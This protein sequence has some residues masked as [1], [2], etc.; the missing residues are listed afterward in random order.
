[1]QLQT[2]LSSLPLK[3]S[4]KS[5]WQALK[6]LSCS[7][8]FHLYCVLTVLFVESLCTVAF[9]TPDPVLALSAF[10]LE[11]QAAIRIKNN[12]TFS[13]LFIVINL[14]GDKSKSICE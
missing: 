10:F 12:R 2:S 4:A 8:L 6:N 11:L 3:S 9:S 13:D 7:V 5:A 1:M 14:N